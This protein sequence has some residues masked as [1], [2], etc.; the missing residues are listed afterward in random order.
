MTNNK[1]WLPDVVLGAGLGILVSR[2]VYH[3]KPLKNWNP[4]LKKKNIAIVLAPTYSGDY[5]GAS[6]Q[7]SF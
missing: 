2:L 5:L 3:W 1:H 4:F 6:L 7:V